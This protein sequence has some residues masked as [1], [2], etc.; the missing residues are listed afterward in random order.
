[1]ILLH[2]S[3]DERQTVNLFGD[4]QETEDFFLQRT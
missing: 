2:L 3:G 4:V 1:M